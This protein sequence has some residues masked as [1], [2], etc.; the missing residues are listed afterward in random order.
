MR[1]K[2]DSVGESVTHHHQ[3]KC[4]IFGS[5]I[6]TLTHIFCNPIIPLQIEN[7]FKIQCDYD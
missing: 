3:I 5:L 7:T 6:H 2:V 1:L 4:N